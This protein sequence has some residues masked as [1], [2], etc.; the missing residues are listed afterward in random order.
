MHITMIGTGYVGLVSG[1]CL[2]DLGHRVTCLDIDAEKIAD[3]D[4]GH[5]PIF[6]PGLNGMIRRNTKKGQLRFATS[7]EAT[8]PGADAVFIAVG[9]PSSETGKADLSYVDSSLEMM[10]PH[11]VAGTTVVMKSTVP[12]G[13]NAD[14]AAHLASLRPDLS[15]AIG[16]NPEFLKQGNAVD[17]FMHPDRI[18]IGADQEASRRVLHQ[19][20]NPLIQSGVPVVYT[21]LET[22]ELIKYA[23]NAFLAMKLSFINEMSD[24]CEMTGASITDVAVGMGLDNRISDRFLAA[25][26]G[27]GGSCFPK[28][29]QALLHTT[30]V[31]GAPSRLVAA[32]VD[33]NRNRLRSMAD[34][35]AGALDDAVLGKRIAV[36]GLTF[37]A[38][39]DDLR[40]SPAIYIIQDLVGRGAEVI[41]YDPEGM[42]RARQALPA[43]EYAADAWSAIEG[44][45]ALVIATE[46]PEFATLDLVRVRENLASPVVIDLRNLFDPTEVAAAGLRYESIGRPSSNGVQKLQS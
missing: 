6:E 2:A 44:A 15:I 29:T 24:L 23:S 35:I 39:T 37:K 4:R 10:A 33:V 5:V 27:F 31:R 41:A 26:P 28:D 46:W 9:T 1:A 19:I 11:L 13:T 45:D 20:Y 38:N 30:Q 17:D 43:I 8:I 22:A 14:V 34:K 16:S 42:E 12:V 3:L 7:Y 36:L 18:V 40:E 25:G 32:A 21:N